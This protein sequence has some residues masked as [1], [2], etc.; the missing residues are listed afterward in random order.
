MKSKRS[1]FY[2]TASLMLFALGCL[3]GCSTLAKKLTPKEE[4]GVVLARRS[5]I[6]SSSAPVAA[7]LVTVNRGDVVDILDSDTVEGERWLQVRAHD[8]QG[9]EGWIEARNIMT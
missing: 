2:L 9:T 7:D 6:R 3:I 8:E 4:T 1:S 5:M